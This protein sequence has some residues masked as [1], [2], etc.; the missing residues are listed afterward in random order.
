[1]TEKM[2]EE[3]KSGEEGATPAETKVARQ[4]HRQLHR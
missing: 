2:E 3:D 4:L 1:M